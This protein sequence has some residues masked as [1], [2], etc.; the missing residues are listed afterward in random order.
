M[1]QVQVKMSGGSNVTFAEVGATGDTITRATGNFIT[2]GFVP[3]MRVSVAG[4]AS[5]NFTNARITAVTATVLTLDTQDLVDEGPVGGITIT[6]TPTLTFAEVGATGDT[7]TRSGG[8][9][10]FL[11]DGFRPGDRISV[12]G[13]AS[14][15]F[16]NALVTAVTATVLTLDTQDLTAEALGVFGVTITCGETKAEWIANLDTEFAPVDDAPRIDIAAGRGRVLSPFSGWFM[17]RSAGWFASWR[18]YQHDL[19]IPTWQKDDGHVT[20]D[21]YDEDG[22]LVEWDDRVDGEAATNAR[23]TSLRTWANDGPPAFIARSLTRATDGSLLGDTHNEA[24]V[25]LACTTVQINSENAAIGQSL[26]LNSDGTATKDSLSLIEARVNAALEF[27]LLTNRGEGPRASL[28][29][30]SIDPNTLFNVAEPLML[31]T[32]NLLLNGTVH[33]VRTAVRVLSG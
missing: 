22:Q 14:N 26:I 19:H 21:L 5:N 33:S 30:W 1:S 27:Q 15:N 12:S 31:G 2:D 11:S 28:A 3:E 32:L 24:V 17:R 18:E 16:T 10:S 29:V 20:A 4:S 8:G 13:T 9:T 7:I 25:N 6:G 23:F